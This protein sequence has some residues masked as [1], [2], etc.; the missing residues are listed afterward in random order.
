MTFGS[1]IFRTLRPRAQHPGGFL[2]SI[3]GQVAIR[4]AG[5]AQYKAARIGGEDRRCEQSEIADTH[6]TGRALADRGSR[7]Y[8]RCPA[9]LLQYAG[10]LV[11]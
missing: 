1:A 9:D 5:G 10:V 11:L 6:Q 2:Q 3:H 4:T 7:H 8:P